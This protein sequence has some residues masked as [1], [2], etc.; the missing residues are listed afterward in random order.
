MKE[1]FESGNRRAEINEN[2]VTFL[3][4][5]GN[6]RRSKHSVWP[7]IV[8]EDIKKARRLARAWVFKARL[9][10]PVLACAS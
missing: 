5:S 4:L 7:P 8:V 6:V 9:G 3:K 2:R 10:D 1:A